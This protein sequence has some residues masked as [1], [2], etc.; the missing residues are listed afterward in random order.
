MKK[1]NFSVDRLTA[2]E[3]P[4]YTSRELE[5]IFAVTDNMEIHKDVDKAS[6]LK[7][8]T[9]NN[10]FKDP[11][12]VISFLK[13][14][15]SEDRTKS[16]VEDKFTYMSSNAP[17]FQQPMESKLVARL[18]A[19]IYQIGRKT[20]LHKYDRE[21]CTMEYYSNMCYPGMVSVNNNYLPHLDP[22]S[23]ACNMYLTDCSRDTGTSFFQFRATDGSLHYSSTDLARHPTAHAEY[24]KKYDKG[25]SQFSVNYRDG[26]ISDW[27]IYEGDSEDEPL[28]RFERYLYIKAHKNMC[29]MYRGNKWHGITYDQ[30]NDTEVRYSLVGVIK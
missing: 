5:D 6:G 9:V 3:F 26:G 13:Q 14:L 2:D 1:R 10:F 25:R 29:S 8:V 11:D 21:Q 17:G 20:G 30:V 24:V 7:Y 18:S 4:R 19:D 28:P 15:P 16:L 22:F 27:R 12:A 23:I